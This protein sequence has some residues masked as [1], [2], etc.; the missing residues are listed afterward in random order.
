M[1]APIPHHPGV[2]RLVLD[3]LPDIDV[4]FLATLGR[5]GLA[6]L[7]LAAAMLWER[8]RPFRG[9]PARLRHDVSNLSL[10]LSNAATLQ[11]VF[12]AA[13]VGT[14]LLAQ[15]S[16]LGLL[17]HSA[18]PFPVELALTLLV[19]D[20]ATY[21]L[22]RLYHAV[23]ILWRLHL[24][25]HT[26]ANLDATTGVRFHTLEVALSTGLRLGLVLA[27]GAPPLGVILYEALL[28]LASQLQHADVRLPARIDHVLRWVVITPNMHRIHHSVR[29]AE[30]NSNFGTVLTCWDR[31]FRSY[32]SRPDVEQIRVGLPGFDAESHSLLRLLAMPFVA[33]P[34]VATDASSDLELSASSRDA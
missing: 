34:V 7:G 26:D 19:L 20:L 4:P 17:H 30:L 33:L 16:G 23:P 27:L 12:G 3:M 32:R 14:A 11:A 2:G 22:H 10:W 18:F 25:H 8:A 15:R 1:V 29:R 31:V 6:V 9:A 13:A 28:L 21:S 24:V 5:V